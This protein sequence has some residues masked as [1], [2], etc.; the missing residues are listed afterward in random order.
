MVFPR[1]SSVLASFVY[2]RD[3]TGIELGSRG[4]GHTSA[5]HNSSLVDDSSASSRPVTTKTYKYYGSRYLLQQ[6]FVLIVMHKNAVLSYMFFYGS[7]L[8][9]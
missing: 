3:Q 9:I 6:D 7:L 8:R 1:S 5:R 2:S 4:S